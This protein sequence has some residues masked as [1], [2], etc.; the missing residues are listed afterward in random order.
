MRFRL[1]CA[2][3]LLAVAAA[4]VAF[5]EDSVQLRFA[6]PDTLVAQVQSQKSKF[7]QVDDQPRTGDN[8]TSQYVLRV[9]RQGDAY[10]VS[11]GDV[12]MDTQRLAA[13][14]PEQR[15]V[16][17]IAA[18]AIPSYRVSAE[19]EFVGIDNLKGFQATMR[20]VMETRFANSPVRDKLK[21]ALDMVTSEAF[22]INLASSDWNW[23]V[24]SWAGFE[25]MLDIGDDYAVT[26]Q[27]PVALVNTQLTQHL[28]FK[29]ARKLPCEREGVTRECIELQASLKPDEAQLRT[30]VTAFASRLSPENAA[31]VS[32]ELGAL[33]QETT[34]EL[35]TEP[36]TLIPHR[37]KL[38]K[39]STAA[40]DG[41]TFRQLEE[42]VETFRYPR[43]D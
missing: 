31:K 37:Y 43:P 8:A 26:T 14:T 19:G 5:A 18:K 25:N 11:A 34:L 36:A 23:M 12:R 42:S 39:A 2:A 4:G 6:W 32:R 17:E 33:N 7:K 21:P 40:G 22:L 35:V 41:K 10:V 30:L 1:Q 28:R 13:M 24:G 16:L 9:Q 20:S 38:R 29:V 27:Q 3:G 15:A